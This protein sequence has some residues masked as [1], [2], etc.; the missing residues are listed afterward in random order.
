MKTT[1]ITIQHPVGLH[2]RPAA[3][4]VKTSQNFSSD[5]NVGCNGKT[6][7]AKSLLGILSLAAM[8]GTTIKIEADGSDEQAAL[9]ALQALAADNFGE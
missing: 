7:N 2:A 3:L 6:V 5:I 9:Q 8:Q 4:F 1:E